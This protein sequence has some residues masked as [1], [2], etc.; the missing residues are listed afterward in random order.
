M[1]KINSDALDKSK[2]DAL[3]DEQ[4]AVPGKRK[5]PIHDERHV[6]MAWD[7]VDKTQGLTDA[8]R[9]EARQRIVRKA[10]ELGVDTKDWHKVKSMAIKSMALNISNDDGHP[11]KMPFS[12][13]LTRID[14]P[15]DAAP[16]GSGGRRIMVSR[17]AA[18]AALHTL[19]GMAVDFTPSFDGHDEQKKIGLIT[20]ANIVGNAIEIS[21]FIYSADFPDT[22]GLIRKLKDSLGF[23]FEAQNLL[24]EDPSADVLRATELTFTGAAI[25]QK[26]KAAYR[27]T[28]LS[29]SA[30]QEVNMNTDEMKALLAEAVAPISKRLDEI[31]AKAKDKVEANS[32][33]R[34]MVEPHAAACEC[35]ASAMEAA[36]VGG[37]PENGHVAVL[38]KMAGNL[39][40]AAAVGHVPHVFRDHDFMHAASDDKAA[41]EKAI[42]DAVDA[43]VKP[44]A[45]KLA[46]A[47]TKIA[48]KV[49]KERTESAAPARVTASSMVTRLLDKAGISAPDADK[50]LK[51]GEVDKMLAGANLTISQKIQVKSELNRM[52]ALAA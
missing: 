35:C 52:G 48:D 20:S 13:V 37:H 47:E 40:A 42:K 14:E 9:S 15:S 3:S 19:L 2:R 27:S 30:D 43:A 24:I 31:E 7:M 5:L 28:N 16:E 51:V 46:A 18:E 17:E 44:I 8:E 36:G 26:D 1:D 45:D 49:A 39:R 21:G 22:A 6:K 10:H 34:A 4:F 12:G 38:R 33:V 25:L 50:P 23:S 41:S 29:A 32:A 11:N